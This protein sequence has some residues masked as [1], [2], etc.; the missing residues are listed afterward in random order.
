M[1]APSDKPPAMAIQ[2][3]LEAVQTT[4]D[5]L[6]AQQEKQADLGGLMAD[7]RDSLSETVGGMQSQMGDILQRL[8]QLQRRPHWQER[9]WMAWACGGLLGAVL[10]SLVWTWT[11]LRASRYEPLLSAVDA[12]LVQ[13]YGALPRPVQEH[14]SAAYA[15]AGVQGPGQRQAKGGPR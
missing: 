9:P 7:C 10:V 13:H 5:R 1:S 4:L 2:D 11:P 6:M 15:R 14:L 8:D 3:A 12:V